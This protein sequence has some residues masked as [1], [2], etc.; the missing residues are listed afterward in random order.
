[1]ETQ[2]EL[3]D[4][5][6]IGTVLDAA[7]VHLS[8]E[9]VLILPYLAHG[10]SVSQAS[11]LV[12]V[13]DEKARGWI[14]EPSF[15]MSLAKLAAVIGGWHSSQVQLLALR[16]W[17]V[18]WDILGQ[19]YTDLDDRDKAEMAK[20]ARFVV[21]SIAPDHSTRHVV[22][23]VV[24]PELN[25]SEGT[26]DVL[27]KRIKELEEGPKDSVEGEYKIE[28]I[29]TVFVCHRDTDLRVVNHDEATGKFQ[30]HV[31]G[32]WFSVFTEHVEK[33]HGMTRAQYVDVFKIEDS[34][35]KW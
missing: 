6:R 2:I 34:I 8:P 18:L 17:E 30:C 26:I 22:H 23:E 25:V 11:K 1:M 7:S 28:E 29:P 20:T 13:S 31:C 5:E 33:A 4:Q 35:I 12:G 16:A 9:Q 32:D 3:L 21:Q 15:N 14:D 24:S 10:M 19:D 27:A